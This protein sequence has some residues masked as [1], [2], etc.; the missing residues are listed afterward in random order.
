[1]IQRRGGSGS[2]LGDFVL[3]IVGSILFV[4]CYNIF[5]GLLRVKHRGGPFNLIVFT[6]VLGSIFRV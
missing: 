4:F 5:P 6:F 1:M 3:A 2:K